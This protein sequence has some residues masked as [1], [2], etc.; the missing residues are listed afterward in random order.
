MAA[1]PPRETQ[2]FP[3][4]QRAETPQLVALRAAGY[5]GDYEIVAGELVLLGRGPVA[6]ASVHVDQQYRF[7]G[8]SDPDDESLVLAL[9]DPVTGDQGVLI[10]AY[11]PSASA[12]EA[13]VLAGLAP[14]PDCPLRPAGP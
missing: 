5:G 10:T 6:L 12:A 9:H 1:D 7:E 11:G 4:Q 2:Q 13:E 3:D 8:A 14:A